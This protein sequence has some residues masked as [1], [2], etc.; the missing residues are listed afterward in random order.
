MKRKTV[1][2]INT[3]CNKTNSIFGKT[4][5][6]I[7]KIAD[8]MLTIKLA[9]AIIVFILLGLASSVIYS[10][11]IGDTANAMWLIGVLSA[12]IFLT[13]GQ[14]ELCTRYYLENTEEE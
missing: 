6:C 8:K 4:I 11:V 13:V 2:T 14:L 1:R 7:V 9:I 5:N 3:I 10:F 12:L